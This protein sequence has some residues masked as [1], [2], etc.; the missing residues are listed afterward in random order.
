M[1]L[2]QYCNTANAATAK[3]LKMPKKQPACSNREDQEY[4]HKGS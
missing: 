4:Q 3:N 2:D 1:T